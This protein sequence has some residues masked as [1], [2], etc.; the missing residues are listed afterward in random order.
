MKYSLIKDWDMVNRFINLLS[1]LKDDE[2]YFLSLSAR[3]KYLTMKERE[4]Y[5]LGRTEMF[6]RRVV[7]SKEQF[8]VILKNLSVLFDERTTKN[9]LPIPEKA[10][11]VYVNINPSSM[12]KAY[13]VF[14]K[15]MNREIKDIVRALQRGKEANYTGIRMMDRK[16]MNA[17]QKCSSRNYFIDI[18]ADGISEDTRDFIIKGLYNNDIDYH[19]IQTQG[20]YH[21]LIRCESIK[22]KDKELYEIRVKADAQCKQGEVIFNKN[23]MIPFPGTL[24]AGKLVRLL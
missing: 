21:F 15:Q 23:K 20:G 7:R 17:I 16:I 9:G 6:S 10:R 24:Q 5:Q 12:S 4:E 19:I 13:F 8:E 3:V 11:V 1:E 18:D 14:N 22:G 2:V